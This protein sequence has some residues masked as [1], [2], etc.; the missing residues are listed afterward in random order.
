MAWSLFHMALPQLLLLS[1]NH[2]RAIHLAFAM[3]LTF[4]VF[5][6]SRKARKQRT[7]LTF[8]D[9]GLAS[10]A[11]L[12]V[13]YGVIDYEG[14]SARA[15]DLLTR[16]LVIGSFIIVILLEATRRAVGKPLPIIA[17]V[18]IAYSF[19]SEYMPEIISFKNASIAKVV[20][21]LSLSTGG[22]FGVPLDVSATT[23]FLF[24]LFG[25]MLDKAGGS[26]YFIQCAYSLLG[27]FK[28]GPAKAAVLA[29]GLTGMVSGSSIANTVTTGT[30]T[31]PLMKKSG[32]S[33]I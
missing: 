22:I 28:G 19:F 9:V 26:Q 32:Y 5:G 3:F 27:R 6:R 10:I 29:S 14:I 13:L 12:A 17:T 18:F 8:L 31:I 33:G 11:A 20:N 16:D 23:V 21:K 4:L 2:V 25:A 1:S 15:G 30:F 24:V 7:T